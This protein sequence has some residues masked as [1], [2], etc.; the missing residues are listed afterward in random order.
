M[1]LNEFGKQ[2]QYKSFQQALHRARRKSY[3]RIV[4]AERSAVRPTK[5][6]KAR[7]KTGAR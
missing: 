6:R 3:E 1:D 2:L 4:A 7:A 5:R